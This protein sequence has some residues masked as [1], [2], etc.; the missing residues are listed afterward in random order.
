VRD[1]SSGRQVACPSCQSQPAISRPLGSRDTAEPTS[2]L[3]LLFEPHLNNT[4]RAVVSNQTSALAYRAM[5]GY[6]VVY[7]AMPV[8]RPVETGQL[9]SPR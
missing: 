1:Q 5:S 8:L 2:Q 4:M 9:A 6:M 3:H 7:S